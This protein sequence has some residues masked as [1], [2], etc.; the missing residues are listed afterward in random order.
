MKKLRMILALVLALCLI[1]CACS[2]NKK[3]NSAT[4]KDAIQNYANVAIGDANATL[5]VLPQRVWNAIIKEDGMTYMEV[6]ENIQDN[7]AGERRQAEHTYGKNVRAFVE[8]TDMYRLNAEELD[9]YG[10]CLSDRYDISIKVTQGCVV[11]GTITFKGSDDQNSE[12]FI[13][14]VLQIDGGWYVAE[15]M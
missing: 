9:Y 10:D 12:E 7:A 6:L 8:Y 3:Q 15:A 11:E 5:N 1:L 14:T 4:Y 13:L 2:A